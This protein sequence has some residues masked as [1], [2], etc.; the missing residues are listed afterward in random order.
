[1]ADPLL[2]LER[3]IATGEA[4]VGVIGLGYVGLPLSCTIVERGIRAIGFDVD[5]DEDRQARARRD[6]HP[7]RPRRAVGEDRVSRGALP[8]R[9]RRRASPASCRPRTSTRFASATRSSSACRR[10]SPRG[11]S[12]ISP[13]SPAPRNPL[14]R[15]SAPGQLVVL[16]STTYPG[17]TDEVVRPILEK[18]GLR[19]GEEIRSRV[20]ARSA[21]TR[22]I[23]PTSRRLDPEGRRRRHAPLRP[24]RGGALRRDHRAR[25]AGRRTRASPSRRSSSRTS[26]AAS[27]SRS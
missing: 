21:R 19:V 17:T 10:R 3:K 22:A 14:R 27:T 9:S 16:E 8:P 1:M 26:S 2:D 24:D 12:P 13:P 5:V 18:S 4:I 25:R 20:L 23:R 11:A 6:L 7:P 15:G